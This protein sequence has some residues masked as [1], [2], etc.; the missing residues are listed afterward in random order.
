MTNVFKTIWDFITGYTRSRTDSL[1]ITT[2]A[3]DA[4]SLYEALDDLY[5]NDT[6][7]AVD[8]TTRRLR[9]VVNRSVEF[10]ASKMI[11]GDKIQIQSPE[12]PQVAIEIDKILKA[13]NFQGKKQAMLRDYAKYGDSFLRVR[14]DAGK[15]IIENVSPIY[16]TDFSDDARGFLTT[17]RIDIPV[18]DRFGQPATYTEYWDLQELRI[19]T[20]QQDIKT[21]IDQMGT[22]DA[23]IPLSEMGINF[24]PV[25]HTKFKDVGN[26]RGQ[27]CVYHALDKIYEANRLATRLHD[28]QFRHNKPVWAVLANASDKEG[29]PIPA[30]RIKTSGLGADAT[31][32]EET[33]EFMFGD[34]VSLP[35]MSTLQ[36]LIPD[37]NFEAA[38]NILKDQMNE[39][40]QDLPELRWYS[41]NESQLSGAA[42]Q[43]LLAGAIDRAMDGRNNFLSSMKR[44]NEMALTIGMFMGIVPANLGT[45][46]SGDFDH[47]IIVDEAFGQTI[48]ERAT[49]LKSLTDAGMPIEVAMKQTGFSEEDIQAVVDINQEKA[50]QRNSDLTASLL[51]FNRG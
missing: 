20:H 33:K 36:A 5:N 50:S 22:P 47:D 46:D 17:L 23:I 19:W 14:G 10:Y 15:V 44:T 2:I 3:G 27:S 11:P 9:T 43:K 21:P 1:Q 16:V 28:L 32:A 29:R 13:S 45:F 4:I 31:S 48:E 49:A 6:A 34:M 42:I 39:L 18:L 30:P 26:L 37:I 12:R 40:E 51:A 35:G 24:I 7:F 25:V 38:L 41:L 8:D